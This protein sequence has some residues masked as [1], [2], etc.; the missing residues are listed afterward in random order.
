M[1]RNFSPEA[2][3][4]RNR[5]LSSVKYFESNPSASHDIYKW[6]KML[7][8]KSKI[9]QEGMIYLFSAWTHLP[10][11]EG[12]LKEMIQFL[13]RG[14][15]NMYFLV[16]LYS[17]AYRKYGTNFSKS[18]IIRKE[19]KER[20]FERLTQEEQA[21]KLKQMFEKNIPPDSIHFDTPEKQIDYY[22]KISKD[23]KY[24]TKDQEQKEKNRL[25]MY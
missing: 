14:K 1:T 9:D 24:K 3:D 19:T 20:K 22:I 25:I 7:P 10:D 5:Y 23:K 6:Y 13:E 11:E 4:L 15:N 21:A 8:Y 16:P 2:T 18:N 12:F 17:Y